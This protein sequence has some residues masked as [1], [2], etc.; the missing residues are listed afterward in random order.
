MA[1]VLYGIGVGPGDPELMTLKAVRLIKECDVIGIPSEDT[2]SCTAYK[3][4]D[5]AVEGLDK[6]E[7]MYAPIP[8][9]TD[10]AELKKAYDDCCSR[11]EKLLDE[12]RDVAFLTLGDP[13]IYSTYMTVHN[14]ITQN[15]YKAEL[16]SGVPSFCAV[17]A[18]LGIALGSRKENIHILSGYY[19]ADRLAE[20]DGTRVLMKS[21]GKVDEVKNKIL[22]T[23]NV[24]ACAV[25]N[26]GMDDEEICFDIENLR[27]DA[28]YF[29]TII[30]KEK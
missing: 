20:Y 24:T 27:D 11:I 21:G 9:T 6:K 25:T 23:D 14:K 26:C 15:G 28:G 13:T 19:N 10:R 2:D 30:V 3:I 17:A 1:G 29:T 4:A 16:V 8:M 18:K 12:G 7:I 5:G 22:N